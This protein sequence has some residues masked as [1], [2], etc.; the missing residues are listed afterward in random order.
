MEKYIINLGID[1]TI[2]DILSKIDKNGE[3][4]VCVVDHDGYLVGLITDGDIRRAILNKKFDRI[5]DVVN[6]NPFTVYRNTTHFDL[7]NYSN[8]KKI[9]QIP[10]IDESGKLTDIYL[11]KETV[12]NLVDNWVVIMAGGR[13]KRLG[14]LTLDT[15][16]PMLKIGDKPILER[17]VLNYK[18]S[19]FV[20]F[21]I[22][23]NY[24]SHVI[25]EYFNDGSSFG[26]NISY[27]K[28]TEPLGTAG[29]LSLINEK[30]NKPFFVVNGDVVSTMNPVH[31]LDSHLNKNCKATICV[32]KVIEANKYAVVNFNQDCMIEDIIEKPENIYFINTGQ[33][34]LD[35]NLLSNMAYNQ[36]IDMPDFLYPLIAKGQ[37]ACYVHDE[38]WLDIGLKENLYQADKDFIGL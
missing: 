14:E 27:L 2:Y 15:P 35:F 17:I 1:T 8:E 19:G 22:S 34:I 5:S 11:N 37:L 10:I 6:R 23:V 33:Y 28:E 24:Q 29:C 21:L 16:K 13:G 12:N 32:K 25:T 38:Y 18:Q 4:F 7:V 20:N 36:Y 30:L 31:M 3:G 26:V 9:K